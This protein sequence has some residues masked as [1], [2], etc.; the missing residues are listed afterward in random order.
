LTLL[1]V[2]RVVQ[3]TKNNQPV[4]SSKNNHNN[5]RTNERTCGGK[6]LAQRLVLL[7]RVHLVR[8]HQSI[9]NHDRSTNETKR[10]YE[11]GGAFGGVQFRFVPLR[12]DVVE[13][14]RV[15][16]LGRSGDQL[17]VVGL[18]SNKPIEFATATQTNDTPHR[19][20]QNVT[21]ITWRSLSSLPNA[22][23]SAFIVSTYVVMCKT[24]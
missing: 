10:T 16:D 3:N 20:N 17:V 22:A 9:S 7:L 5:K 1:A 24:K 19:N 11:S 2:V 8:L 23:N 21:Q 13:L 18:H 14:R 4:R 12:L 6:L 15:L